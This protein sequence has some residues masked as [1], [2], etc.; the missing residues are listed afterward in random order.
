M[1][2]GSQVVTSL[3]FVFWKM[4][5]MLTPTMFPVPKV[6]KSFDEKGVPVDKEGVDKRASMFMNELLWSIEA[7]K[8]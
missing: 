2:G 5:A 7:V 3:E 8:K 1:F 4:K 6:Y